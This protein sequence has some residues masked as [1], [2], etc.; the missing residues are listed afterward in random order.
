M[1]VSASS[2]PKMSNMAFS[3][4]PLSCRQLCLYWLGYLEGQPGQTPKIVPLT[5]FGLLYKLNPEEHPI[6]RGG[7]S[8]SGNF[9]KI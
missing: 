7:R 6:K 4:D 1:A 5:R 3:I 2:D 8:I 9:W